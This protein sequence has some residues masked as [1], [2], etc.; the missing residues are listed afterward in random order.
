MRVFVRMLRAARRSFGSLAQV[1]N[2]FLQLLTHCFEFSC[3]RLDV[4]GQMALTGLLHPGCPRPE[5]G[6]VLGVVRQPVRQKH[7]KLVHVFHVF[8]LTLDE[9][10]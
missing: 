3:G 6:G 1:K 8:T 2:R 10:L 7:A 9:Q 4:L 5:L